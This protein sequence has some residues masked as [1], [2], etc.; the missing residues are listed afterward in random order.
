MTHADSPALETVR[1]VRRVLGIC[2]VTIIFDGYDLIV[3]GTVLPRLP[4]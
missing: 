1:N 2:W 3:Y 4:Q